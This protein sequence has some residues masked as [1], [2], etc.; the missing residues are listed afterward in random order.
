MPFDQGHGWGY[1]YF[2]S[3]WFVLPLLAARYVAEPGVE[4][5]PRATIKPFAAGLVACS[6]LLVIPVYLFGTRQFVA[7]L[8]DQVPPAT[9]A[10]PLRLTFVY[11]YQG[12]YSADLIQNDP[13]LR[14]DDLRMMGDKPASD[15]QFAKSLSPEAK[16]VARASAGVMWQM[17][18][19]A[20]HSSSS[21]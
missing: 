19:S 11:P 15:A 17:P 6:L 5:E 4:R 20:R 16:E 7:Q 1:R 21:P 12:I 18:V 14:G 2:H 10:G 3:A 8:I 9:A 13:F